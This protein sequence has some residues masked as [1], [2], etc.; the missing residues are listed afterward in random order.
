MDGGGAFILVKNE[1]AIDRTDLED[2]GS[3][4]GNAVSISLSYSLSRIALAAE[5]APP[6]S[7]VQ[8]YTW[9]SHLRCWIGF[10]KRF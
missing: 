9:M 1:F 10:P 3:Q 8:N 5:Y 4:V 2:H 7:T 6:E